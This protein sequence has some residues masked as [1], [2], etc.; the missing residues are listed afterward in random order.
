MSNRHVSNKTKMVKSA[1]IKQPVART[2]TWKPLNTNNLIKTYDGTTKTAIFYKMI[3]AYILI[4]FNENNQPTSCW[5]N[6]TTKLPIYTKYITLKN[7][8]SDF[9]NEK[10]NEI[11]EKNPFLNIL[12]EHK[13]K[14]IYANTCFYINDY[15][16][17]SNPTLKYSSDELSSIINHIKNLK[18]EKQSLNENKLSYLD[19]KKLDPSLTLKEYKRFFV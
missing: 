10:L 3:K 9:K 1:T 14:I 15:I 17:K 6:K 13:P 8:D 5:T 18:I 4:L 19:A 12:E 7:E 2:N 11:Y 16:K